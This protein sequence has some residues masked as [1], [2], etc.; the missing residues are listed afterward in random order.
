MDHAEATR[1][2]AAEQYLLGE[3]SEEEALEFERHFFACADCAE[4]VEAGAALAANA[5]KVLGK[6]T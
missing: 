6:N 3:M 1:K 5:R 2:S 4:A